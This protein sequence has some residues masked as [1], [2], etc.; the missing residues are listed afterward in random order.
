MKTK[1][2]NLLGDHKWNRERQTRMEVRP[3]FSLPKPESM[4]SVELADLVSLVV[5]EFLLDLHKLVPTSW[6]G[7]CDDKTVRVLK[8]WYSNLTDK[9]RY[10]VSD[11]MLGLL[12]KLSKKKD[13]KAK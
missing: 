2:K 4:K 13:K 9:E 3:Y 8:R 6:C 11:K 1:S 5:L 10:R 12:G 7:N